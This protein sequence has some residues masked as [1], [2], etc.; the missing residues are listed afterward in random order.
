MKIIKKDIKH[1]K[2]VIKP[3]ILDD[4]WILEK[5]IEKDDLISGKTFRSITM[6]RDGVNVKTGKRPVFLKIIA[7][8]VEYNEHELRV[9]GKIIEGPDE[10]SHGYHTFEIKPDSIV[11]I[12]KPNNWHEWQLKRLEKAAV[13]P[14]KILVCI[15]D[16]K[17]A[18]FASI[19]NKMDVLASIQ[20]PSGKSFDGFEEA[21]K[22]YYAEVIDF[23]K[24][25]LDL[26]KYE[27]LII[28]GPGFT[29]ENILNLI[30]ND[31]N[32]VGKI[33]TDSVS[34]T[35]IAG[36]RELMNRGT[37][38]LVSKE[39]EISRQTQLI[40]EFFT[41]ISKDG[42]VEYGLSASRSAIENGNCEMLLIADTEVKENEDLIVLAE[43]LRAEVHIIDTHHE[44]GK[45]FSLFG[46]IAV[47]LRYKI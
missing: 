38:D 41:Q 3:E 16:E 34:H 12:E 29:K 9:K 22:K 35:G 11:T 23:I 2:L 5:I 40:D 1:G 39:S 44:A 4:L 25:K 36:F 32:L 15:I 28:A 31:K 6:Q 30:K 14:V 42:L 26:G 21:K 18:D 19:G 24:N 7:E 46:G 13:K 45:R 47:F 37:I 27:K 33:I 17:E 10:V 20:G 8:G 43:Q